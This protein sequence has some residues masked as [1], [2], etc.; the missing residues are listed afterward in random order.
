MSAYLSRR[1]RTTRTELILRNDMTEFSG[2]ALEGCCV[3]TD[4]P[5]EYLG[6]G[7][8]VFLD[9]GEGLWNRSRRH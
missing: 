3:R 1:A 8:S 7:R 5:A 4:R 6:P 9:S 2:T